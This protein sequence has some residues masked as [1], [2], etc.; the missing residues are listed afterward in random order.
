[1]VDAIVEAITRGMINRQAAM[2]EVRA[3]LATIAPAIAPPAVDGLHSALD[4][5]LAWVDRRARTEPGL[6]AYVLSGTAGARIDQRRVAFSAVV[7]GSWRAACAGS[8][9]PPPGSCAGRWSNRP[10][11]RSR[12]R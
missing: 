9:T 3:R 4:A 6:A 8:P 1:M 2:G 10:P 11:P 5:F 12:A 7:P